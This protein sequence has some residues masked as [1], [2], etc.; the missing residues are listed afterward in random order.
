MLF[1]ASRGLSNLPHIGSHLILVVDLQDI[2]V[3]PITVAVIGAGA[4][5]LFAAMELQ[6]RRPHRRRLRAGNPGWGDLSLQTRKQR[7]TRWDSIRPEKS[8]TLVSTPLCRRTCRKVM[9]FRAYP[10]VASGKPDRD[11]RRFGSEVSLVGL[12]EGRKWSVRSKIGNGGHGYD[13][14][15]Y[16]DCFG[17]PEKIG[18][19]GTNIED[20]KCSSLVVKALELCNEEQKKIL[21]EHYGKDNPADV[22]KIKALYHELNLQGIFFEYEAKSY[23][24][25]TS[26]I[27]AIPRKPVQA[28]L[29]SFL[30]KIYKRKK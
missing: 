20:F 25:L 4:A 2:L 1:L 23:D 10:F 13:E 19:I 5:G 11:P 27:K 17:E 7:P 29:K 21:Y 12:A 15:D 6:Q 9:G 3:S 30:A 14:D 8:S 24:R 16:L 22:S 28:V 26:S 18:K